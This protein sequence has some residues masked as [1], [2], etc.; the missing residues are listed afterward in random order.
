MSLRKKSK[1]SS[2]ILSYNRKIKINFMEN[3]NQKPDAINNKTRIIKWPIL[4]FLFIFGTMYVQIDVRG[5]IEALRA[6]HL[7]IP[8]YASDMVFQVKNIVCLAIGIVMLTGF[9]GIFLRKN[10]GR[11]AAIAGVSGQAAMYLSEMMIFGLTMFNYRPTAGVIPIVI[12]D[13]IIIR[14]LYRNYHNIAG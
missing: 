13:I 1:E 6:E 9:S 5:N 4:I 12:I 2:S 7:D 11:T 8:S 3:T 14:Y 10:Y